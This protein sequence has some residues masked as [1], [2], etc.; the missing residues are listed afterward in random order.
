M[1]EVKFP[2]IVEMKSVAQDKKFIYIY[3][4][5]IKYGNLMKVLRNFDG[6]LERKLAEFYAA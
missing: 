6:K 3:Q 2:L 5:F 4:E 1:S